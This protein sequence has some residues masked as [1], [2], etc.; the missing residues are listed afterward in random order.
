MPETLT[1]AELRARVDELEANRGEMEQ[2]A[3][4]ADREAE[5]ARAEARRNRDLPV[6]ATVQARADTLRRMLAE[7]DA[8]LGDVRAELAT[9]EVVERRNANVSELAGL[10]AEAAEAGDAYARALRDGNRAMVEAARAARAARQRAVAA[11]AAF[12]SGL[13]SLAPGVRTLMDR[14]A[15]PD[16][17]ERRA[18]LDAVLAE[19]EARGADMSGVRHRWDPHRPATAIDATLRIDLPEPFGRMVADAAER[20]AAYKLSENAE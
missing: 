5:A 20:P 6:P 10:S 12:L 13:G 1:A 4:A 11:R 3:A 19:L 18:D 8:E 17:A 7:L 9:V 14:A 15:R 2:E 16:D